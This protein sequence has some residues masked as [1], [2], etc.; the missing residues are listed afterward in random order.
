MVDVLHT[1]NTSICVSLSK[2]LLC[3][4]LSRVQLFVTTWTIARQL[5]CLWKSP[6][7]NTGVGCHFLPHGIFLNQGSKP[8]LPL[9][10]QILY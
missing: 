5:L 3:L 9:C 10:R 8:G 2:G 1:N 6:G 7:K 4:V